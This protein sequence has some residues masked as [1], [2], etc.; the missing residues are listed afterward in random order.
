MELNGGR[1]EGF[2]V[3]MLLVLNFTIRLTLN[4]EGGGQDIAKWIRFRLW[5]APFYFEFY[6][7]QFLSQID[8]YAD[9]ITILFTNFNATATLI[10]EVCYIRLQ[11]HSSFIK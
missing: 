11:T 5:T 10:E 1:V 2:D 4:T 8:L 3:T 9:V 7:F 6:R